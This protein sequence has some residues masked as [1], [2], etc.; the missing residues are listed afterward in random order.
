MRCSQ[1][2]WY[3]STGW[4]DVLDGGVAADAQWVLVF[5]ARQAWEESGAL[6]QLRAWYPR[7]LMM[8]CSTAGEIAGE[9]VHDNTLVAT[10]VRF[11]DTEL[12][13]ATVEVQGAEDS[14]AAS[15]TLAHELNRPGLAHVFLLAG[16]LQV[17]GSALARGMRENLPASV[18][19][20]G[21][22]A[23]DADR[24]EK[25]L[26]YLGADAAENRII[27]IGFYGSRIRVG[28]GSLGGWDSFGPQRLITRSKGNVLY[29]LDGRS[30]LDLYKEYLGAYAAGLPATA[31][32]FPL[33]LHSEHSAGGLVRTVL[34]VDEHERSV[35]FAG[36]MPQGSHARLM[37]TNFDHLVDGAA[38]AARGGMRTLDGAMPDL[39]VLVSC[40]GRKQ[41]LKQRVEEELEAVRKILGPQAAM[42]GFYSYGEIGPGAGPGAQCELHNQTMTIT[43]FTES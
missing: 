35:I 10:A 1:K 43:T 9:Q 28:H 20:T 40:V 26:V 39:A 42:A 3:A 14:Q 11:D 22:L 24:F 33:A 8:G 17:N 31:L 23:G 16:G 41:V 4:T 18:A 25:T 29:E 27:A 30:A 19:V 32:L 12:R 2:I 7:A 38:G 36:D 37:K 6:E 15:Q 34:G 5:G 21:G 13:L